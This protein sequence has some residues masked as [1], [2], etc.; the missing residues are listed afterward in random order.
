MRISNLAIILIIAS[1]FLQ[2]DANARSAN[3]MIAGDII[4]QK[5]FE[6]DATF[7]GEIRNNGNARALFVEITFA[8]KNS[9]G[10][11]IGNEFTFVNSTNLDPGQAS[12]F[13][14]Y[15]DI[16]YSQISSWDYEITWNE[17][18]PKR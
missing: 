2:C 12:S 3:C 11:V 6:G 15:T 16:P 8:I 5:D 18:N 9:D 1:L 14:C 17:E 4:A 13:K 10:S 7:Q